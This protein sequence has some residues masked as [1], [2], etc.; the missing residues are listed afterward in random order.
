MKLI[1]KIVVETT[2]LNK[3][4]IT[5]ENISEY[6]KDVYELIKSESDPNANIKIEVE[7]EE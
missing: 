7:F 6:K 5:T 4:D 1:T 2:G 3:E